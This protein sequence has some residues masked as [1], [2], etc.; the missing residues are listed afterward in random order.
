MKKKFERPVMNVELYAPNQAVSACSV[1]DGG[2][3]YKFDCMRGPKVDT[4]KVISNAL[5]ITTCKLS[6]GYASGSNMARD[7]F[8][9]KENSDNNPGKA[10]WVREN[11]YVQV[12]YS[13]AQ[14]LLY[15]DG[16]D[17]H[18]NSLKND[19][20]WSVANGIVTH[21]SKEGGQHHMVAP[22][23]NASTISSS[24]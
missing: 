13:G 4:E 5:G 24:W 20:C 14:G 1:P 19:G 18:S 6:I 22:V 2:I 15:T 10:T 21:D 16:V 12:T 17:K 3:E 7:Y 9:S 11:G 8:N 23:M